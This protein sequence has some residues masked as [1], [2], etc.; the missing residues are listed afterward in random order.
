MRAKLCIGARRS[1][2]DR[3]Y[4]TN[5]LF[6][7]RLLGAVRLLPA[8]WRA[9]LCIGA[10]R[11]ERHGAYRADDFFVPISRPVLS[12]V[13][14][15]AK[16]ASEKGAIIPPPA[17]AA[18]EDCPA[19]E[20]WHLLHIHVRES[21]RIPSAPVLVTTFLADS[22]HG[23]LVMIAAFSS[24]ARASHDS[25]TASILEISASSPLLI[26]TCR[27]TGSSMGGASNRNLSEAASTIPR[28][29]WKFLVRAFGADKSTSLD[30]CV[31]PRNRSTGAW[32]IRYA[33]PR[34]LEH[35]RDA[36]PC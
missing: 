6:R 9:K 30:L 29:C 10:R 7:V 11:S 17:R 1:E 23:H 35:R 20:V 19:F 3:A 8:S 31:Q 5:D 32:R 4:R 27:R 12:H 16:I 21:F 14:A 33:L 26:R 36:S 28:R 18:Y 13:A 22:Y 24:L 34:M 25:S 2:H 15:W